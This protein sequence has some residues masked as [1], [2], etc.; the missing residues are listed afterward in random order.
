MS[1]ICSF[2]VLCCFACGAQVEITAQKMFA[3]EKTSTAVFSGS[4]AIKRAKDTIKAEKITLT[5]TPNREVKRFEA[6]HNCSFDVTADQNR[7]FTGEA[8][9]LEY[10]PF[11]GIYKLRGHAWIEDIN[12]KRKVYGERI[13]LN[14]KTLSTQV[15]GEEKQPVKLI[16]TIKDKNESDR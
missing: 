3:D 16:I 13:E 12:D 7:R 6:E 11:E 9:Y 14:E 1:K 2:F 15:I 10:L 5:F 4:V 8:D